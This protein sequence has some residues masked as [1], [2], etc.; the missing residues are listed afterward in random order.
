[1]SKLIES[2]N[3]ELEKEIKAS[4]AQEY[5]TDKSK[6]K[7][8]SQSRKIISGIMLKHVYKQISNNLPYLPFPRIPM[9]KATLKYVKHGSSKIDT[10]ARKNSIEK[11]V[12]ICYRKEYKRITDRLN[13]IEKMVLAAHPKRTEKVKKTLVAHCQLRWVEEDYTITKKKIDTI[14][15]T[16]LNTLK[17]FQK[18]I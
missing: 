2:M 9:E 16:L 3:Y 11:H 10:E 4:E 13:T 8:W 12:F 6:R 1:M 7:T 5:E 18:R 15:T 14:T 17:V